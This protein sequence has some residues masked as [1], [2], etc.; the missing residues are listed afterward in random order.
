ML[1][2][3]KYLMDKL[4]EAGIHPPVITSQKMLE[5]ANDLHIGA[6]IFDKTLF[7]RNGS[8]KSYKDHS[9]A[10][11]VRTKIYDKIS[12]YKVIIG[13]YTPEKCEEIVDAFLAKLGSGP[14]IAGNHVQVDVVEAVYLTEDDSILKSKLTC[15]LTVTCSGG[16]YKD[17]IKEPKSIGT[18]NLAK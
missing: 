6:V 3:R 16:I 5:R 18:V 13:E 10:Q 12:T 7:T 2:E 15:E 11:A 4:L 8:K 1:Q 17:T 14:K 9:G